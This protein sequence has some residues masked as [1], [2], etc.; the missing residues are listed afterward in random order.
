MW[1][2]MKALCC[3]IYKKKY[4]IFSL[5]S[6]Y[7][8]KIRIRVLKVYFGEFSYL[9]ISNVGWI[10]IFELDFLYLVNYN[11]LRT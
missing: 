8:L 3:T 2:G 5:K 6:P 1:F 10:L 11:A 9:L 4:D 7:K